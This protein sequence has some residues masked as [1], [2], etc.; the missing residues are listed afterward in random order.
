MINNTL[1]T[2]SHRVNKYEGS[3]EVTEENVDPCRFRM[4][5]CENNVGDF[6]CVRAHRYAQIASQQRLTEQLR[7]RAPTPPERADGV[8]LNGEHNYFLLLKGY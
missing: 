3:C 8:M 2:A 6:L 1:N 7:E 5:C 4:S